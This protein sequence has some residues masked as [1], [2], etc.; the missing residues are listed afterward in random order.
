[1]FY[2]Q[3][4]VSATTYIIIL[5]LINNCIVWKMLH[6]YILAL[7]YYLSDL[8]KPWCITVLVCPSINSC[9]GIMTTAQRMSSFYYAFFKKYYS[10]IDYG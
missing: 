9:S 10:C 5:Y 6:A 3:N 7:W 1:M 2:R 4:H 8:A